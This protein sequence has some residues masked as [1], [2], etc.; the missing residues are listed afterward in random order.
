MDKS[1]LTVFFA[2]V[3]TRCVLPDDYFQVPIMTPRAVVHDTQ[4]GLNQL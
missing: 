2:N 3:I 1:F 4:N